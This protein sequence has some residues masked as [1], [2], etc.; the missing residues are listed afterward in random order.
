MAKAKAGDTPT[1]TN[2]HRASAP[3]FKRVIAVVVALEHYRR[4]SSG[5]P[6]PQVDFAHA[7]ADAFSAVVRDI[8]RDLPA[9]DVEIAVIKD[10]HASLTALRDE[11]H[12]KIKHLADDD[13][14]IFYYAGHGFH[15]A[16]GNR[17]SAYDTNG[18]NVSSTS[19]MMRDDL[20]EPLAESSCQWA[21][22]FVD[23][24]AEQF[25]DL[26]PSRDVISNL[27]AEEVEDFLE[28]GWHC[29]VFLSC[30]PGEKSYPSI[31]LGHG[32]WTHFLLQALSGQAEDAL[33][34]ERW[35]T[36]SGLR[37]YLNQEVP[38]FLTREM[39]VRGTQTPQAILTGSNTFNIRHVPQPPAI[40][41][42]AAL[43]GIKL[44]NHSEFLE[45]AET[46]PIA[47]LDGFQRGRHR[48]PTDINPA[49]ENWCRTLLAG[50]VAA[51][52]QDVY[53][54]TRAALNARR[55]DVAK[56][57]DEGGGSLDTPAFRYIVESGQN[58]EDPSEYLIQRRLE[59]RQGWGA[60]RA[61]IDDLFDTEF[62]RLV[63][64][65]ERMDETFDSLVDKL[66]DV[67]AAQGG[68][69]HDDDR[70][71]RVTYS[72]DGVTFAFD[73]KKRRLEISFGH[74]GALDLVDAAQHYQLGLDQ[75]SS[76][77]PSPSNGSFTLPE[78]GKAQQD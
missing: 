29:G 55:K 76:M 77:L 49:A 35:L 51:E 59:L 73:M 11:L 40:P 18:Y 65:F 34:R 21:L 50:K 53:E 38:R 10:E 44:R 42:N 12:Y 8:Y 22:V 67:E 28:S 56:A 36:D 7:D 31:K 75:P 19:L 47:R 78:A 69:V 4:P 43:A 23:A 3:P 2:Q 9:E 68:K 26:F 5:E 63:I 52:M 1:R 62:N 60:H 45:G 25:K 15:G 58:P 16:G 24:C 20:L 74:D 14:F 46:G 30:S 39:R 54:R 33:T 6:L 70:A 41:A 64:E 13:L 61:A 17:L 32:V 48:V 27:D 37:D 66:E 72:R 71:K 57:S